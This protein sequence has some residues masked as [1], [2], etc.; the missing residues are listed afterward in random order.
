VVGGRREAV[1]LTP[2]RLA[3]WAGR[4]DRQRGRRR[5]GS[6]GRRGTGGCGAQQVR[7]GVL[8]ADGPEAVRA[9]SRRVVHGR[10]R[11]AA[12]RA[13]P[14]RVVPE[15]HGRHGVRA[16]RGRCRHAAPRRYVRGGLRGARSRH[17]HAG[18]EPRLSCRAV[19]PAR[20]PVLQTAD[21]LGAP[22]LQAV[23][24]EQSSEDGMVLDSEGEGE[25]R[26]TPRGGAS[27]P[28]HGGWWLAVYGRNLGKKASDLHDVHPTRLLFV[29]QRTCAPLVPRKGRDVSN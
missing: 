18:H 17:G 5:R 22:V 15:P 2:G 4:G 3:R 13:L 28:W 6:E 1:R 9:V 8:L 21:P 25:W 16:V 27:G 11:G 24:Y 20:P 26:P 14:A 29:R 12:V 23:P 7:A 19:S 10:R